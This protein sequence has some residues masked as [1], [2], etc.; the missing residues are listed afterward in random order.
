MADDDSYFWLRLPRRTYVSSRF[1]TSPLRFVSR[2]FETPGQS[3]LVIGSPPALE[4]TLEGHFTADEPIELH[5]DAHAVRIQYRLKV[6]EADRAIEELVI[7]KH[8]RK[9]GNELVQVSLNKAAVAKLRGLIGALPDLEFPPGGQGERMDDPIFDEDELARDLRSAQGRRVAR[10]HIAA[11]GID[12][13]R[14]VLEEMPGE[15]IAALLP[16]LKR[17]SF[18]RELRENVSAVEQL[19]DHLVTGNM[20]LADVAELARRRRGIGEFREKLGQRLDE[21]AWQAFFEEHRWIFGVG[22][23]LRLLVGGEGLEVTVAG[24]LSNASRRVDALL[25]SSAAAHNLVIVEIKRPDTQLVEDEHYRRGL[26]NPSEHLS[27]GVAQLAHAAQLLGS[28]RQDD[29][30]LDLRDG[31]RL[32]VRHHRPRLYLLIGDL[33]SLVGNH[34]YLEDKRASFERYRAGL[35]DVEVI[36]YDELFAR[37]E[38][39][40]EAMELRLEDAAA[41][42]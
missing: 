36:T 32:R 30:P 8:D 24:V 33:G 5:R 39:M 37:A 10:Q 27:G 41:L 2:V 12:E 3:E 23:E 1:K 16:L 22:L 4:A 7:T 6:K 11:G 20:R 17:E 40:V 29:T 25:R 42:G 28:D 18:Q 35:K 13:L 19:V 31:T 15:A 26:Y 9:R 34:S 38:R 14:Q 21:R